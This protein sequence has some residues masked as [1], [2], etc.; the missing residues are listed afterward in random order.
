MPIAY[1]RDDLR[2]LITV[3]VTEPYAIDE[4]LGVI[5]RQAAEDTWSYAMLYDLRAGAHMATEADLQQLGVRAKVVGG[6]RERGPVGLAIGTQSRWGLLYTEL[7]RKLVTVE[8]LL[9]AAQLD[10]WLARNARGSSCEP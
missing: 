7:I 8:V 1:E 10:A 4:I 6:G 9:T 2:R 5:D 3:T